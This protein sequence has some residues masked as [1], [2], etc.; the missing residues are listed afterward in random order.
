[1]NKVKL[2]REVRSRDGEFSFISFPLT[3]C[4]S[5]EK[6][7]R[8]RNRAGPCRA[9]SLLS[10]RMT[11]VAALAAPPCTVGCTA[12]HRGLQRVATGC[13]VQPT[14]KQVLVLELPNMPARAAFG[15]RVSSLHASGWGPRGLART[16]R[17][18]APKQPQSDRHVSRPSVTPFILFYTT[19]AF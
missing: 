13:R 9:A 10:L 7:G 6:G 14:F 11:G 4:C 16:R 15:F 5:T 18:V 17:K 8:R 12:L 1:M 3:T 19:L 2:S